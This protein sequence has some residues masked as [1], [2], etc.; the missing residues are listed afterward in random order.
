LATIFVGVTTWN[1]HTTIYQLPVCSDCYT[2]LRRQVTVGRIVR[3]I[4]LFM[5]AAGAVLALFYSRALGGI[6]FLAPSMRLPTGL[7]LIGLLAFVIAAILLTPNLFANIGK[8][9]QFRNPIF[10]EAF[11]KANPDQH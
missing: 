10:Q 9:I 3:I 2:T 8:R 5:L 1:V 4:S 6:D 11:E 7:I